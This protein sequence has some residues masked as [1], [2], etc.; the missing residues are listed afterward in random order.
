VALPPGGGELVLPTGD[1]AFA[2]P[3]GDDDAFLVRAIRERSSRSRPVLRLSLLNR[4]RAA[5]DADGTSL[6][7]RRRHSEILALLCASPTG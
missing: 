2:E 5:A 7:P 1:A 6:A 3:V 4:D